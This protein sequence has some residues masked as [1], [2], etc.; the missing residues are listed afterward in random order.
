M[1]VSPSGTRCSIMDPHVRQNTCVSVVC[2][3][4]AGDR[5]LC[6]ALCGWC[7]C[8]TPL[9]HAGAAL[10]GRLHCVWMH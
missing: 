8:C 7:C 10:K 1:W 2:A 4:A 6:C 3:V 5:V 9:N